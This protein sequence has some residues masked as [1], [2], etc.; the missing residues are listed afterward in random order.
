MKKKNI[1]ISAVLAAAMLAGCGTQTGADGHKHTAQ[2]GW[3]L[4]G[5]EHWKTCECGEKMEENLHTWDDGSEVEEG[6]K[7]YLCR[8][9]NAEKTEE[10]QLETKGISWLIPAAIAG[11]LSVAALLTVLIVFGRRFRK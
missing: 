10:I 3:D 2:G 11:L 4:N 7:L 1:I 8:I 9:C 6:T 5:K